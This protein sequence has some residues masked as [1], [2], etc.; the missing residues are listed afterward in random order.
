MEWPKTMQIDI[1]ISSV[2]ASLDDDT[3]QDGDPWLLDSIDDVMSSFCI[4]CG[5]DGDDDAD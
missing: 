5:V 3:A 2:S 1:L 4:Y